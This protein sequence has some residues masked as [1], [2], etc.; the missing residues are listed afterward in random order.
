MT[1]IYAYLHAGTP[2]VQVDRAR[3]ELQHGLSGA[4]GRTDEVV[5]N[6]EQRCLQESEHQRTFRQRLH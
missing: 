1:R 5:E 2:A 6:L 3:E 4:R